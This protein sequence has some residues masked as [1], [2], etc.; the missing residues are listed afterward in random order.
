[1]ATYA[2]AVLNVL[3]FAADAICQYFIFGVP[4]LTLLGAKVNGLI[5]IYHQWWRLF[6]PMFLHSGMTH[7]ICNLAALVIWG[8]QC[9]ALLGKARFLIVYFA[10][11]LMGSAASLCFS[12]AMSVGASGA[13]FGLF[14]ALLVFRKHYRE[15]FN[16]VFGASVVVIIV[17]NLVNGLITPNIDNFGHIGGLIGGWLAC[18]ATGFYGQRDH[19]GV[20][21][22]FAVGFCL[23]AAGLIGAAYFRAV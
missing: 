12:S 20:R 3:V 10:S 4:A 11:G 1:M 18:G 14:G 5:L 16:A 22:G 6:T 9:E 19:G 13:I 2:L 7:L 23:L 8:R 21:A 15:I 17:I